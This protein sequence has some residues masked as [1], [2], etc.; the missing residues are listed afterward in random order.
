MGQLTLFGGKQIAGFDDKRVFGEFNLEKHANVIFPPIPTGDPQLKET[1]RHQLKSFPITHGPNAGAICKPYLEIIP[2]GDDDGE[3]YNTD[4]HDVLYSLYK[5]WEAMA[6]PEEAFAISLRST[7]TTIN[8]S[9]GQKSLQK[10]KRALNTLF[11]TEVHFK[12][13]FEI[14]SGESEEITK[15]NTKRFRILSTYDTSETVH[16]GEMKRGTAWVAF[17]PEL[18]GSLLWGKLIPVNMVQRM[19]IKHDLSRSVYGVYDTY[20]TSSYAKDPRNVVREIRIENLLVDFKRPSQAYKSYRK[21]TALKIAG[22]IN[23]AELSREGL[24]MTV[25]ARETAD[26]KDYKLVFKVVGVPIKKLAKLS[27][28]NSEEEVEGMIAEATQVIGKLQMD[29]RSIN[30]LSKKFRTTHS[31]VVY[32]AISEL[33]VEM[34][35]KTKIK[36]RPALLQGI[37]NRKV[38]ELNTR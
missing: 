11:S 29:T 27:Y 21:K 34:A 9:T 2:P 30:S 20:L 16:N 24:F 23:G 33:K 31:N 37:I 13:C 14:K 26:E 1:A 35:S 36:S 10:V 6:K 4:T 38:K 15:T 3:R 22:E 12:E 7:A 18:L 25:I 8:W 32:G 19:S 28:I 17:N 5:Q